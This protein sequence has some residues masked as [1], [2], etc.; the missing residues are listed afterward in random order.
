MSGRSFT[1]SLFSVLALGMVSCVTETPYASMQGWVMRQNSTPR[2][3]AH[4][5]IFFVPPSL[6]SGGSADSREWTRQKDTERIYNFVYYQLVE[7]FGNRIRFFVPQINAAERAE[8]ARY[9]AEDPEKL[10]DT[11]FRHVIENTLEAF[12]YYLENYHVPG[13]PF[14]I[15]GQG[16]GA[17]AAYEMMKR[18]KGVAPENGF[19]AAYLTGMPGLRRDRI[20]KDFGKRGIVPA[21]GM[22]DTGV[23]LGWCVK[24]HSEPEEIPPDPERYVINPLSW[25]TDDAAV[26]AS[27]N[28]RS[29]LYNEFDPNPLERCLETKHCCGAAIDSRNGVLE[30]LPAAGQEKTARFIAGQRFRCNDMGLFVQ[31]MRINM[32][33][34]VDQYRHDIL[35]RNREQRAGGK[36]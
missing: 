27:A 23:I 1:L 10:W 17:L 2:Y 4:Y 34:R 35:W 8:A 29:I 30:L 12:E 25:R 21:R 31:S 5:D 16:Q 14:I 20:E 11:P 26:P 24:G 32:K 15:A 19:V 28:S 9:L 33:N 3:F 7:P 18:C 36:N 22:T 6:G 13:R